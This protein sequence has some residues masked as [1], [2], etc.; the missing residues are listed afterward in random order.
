MRRAPSASKAARAIWVASCAVSGSDRPGRSIALDPRQVRPC[1][2]R[3]RAHRGEHDEWQA[4]GALDQHL[5]HPDARGV[6]PVQVVDH[7]HPWPARLDQ[8]VDVPTCD[9]D[10]RGRDRRG[11]GRRVGRL[12]L[13]AG[14]GRVPGDRRDRAA[15]LAG[16]GL[17]EIRCEQQRPGVAARIH[18]V[19]VGRRLREHPPEPVRLGQPVGRVLGPGPGHPLAPRVGFEIG[20]EPRLPDARLPDDEDGPADPGRQALV[21][22]GPKLLPFGDAA[23]ER[24]DRAGPGRRVAAQPDLALEGME[25]DGLRLAAQDEGPTVRNDQSPTGGRDGRRVEQDLR[26]PGQGLDPGRGR[27]GRPGQGEVVAGRIRARG[28]HFAG[29]DPDPDLHRVRA[30]ARGPA[31]TSGWPAR[32]EP[33][34]RHRHRGRG[35]SR[36]PR[37][38]RRR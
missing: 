16:R 21:H 10:Q 33:P 32:R 11:V 19:L 29:R 2:Q 13:P 4:R 27:D 3:D 37:R 24:A 18:P 22:E 38:R 35:A 8:A 31:A 14:E 7:D 6:D 5:D 26:R 17:A 9:V 1:G 36:R 34:G 12:G 25:S 23:H 20:E 28:D 15:V 30:I